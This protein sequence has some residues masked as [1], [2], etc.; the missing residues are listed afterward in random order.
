MSVRTQDETLG[1]DG[2][3]WFFGVVEDRM[4]PLNIGRVRV[5]CYGWHTD[6]ITQVPTESLPWAQ[7]MMP[8]NS[9]SISSI[10]LSGTGLVEGSTV[11]GFFLDGKN[12]Q[13]PMII[14]SIPGIPAVG[15][16]DGTTGFHDP[17]GI[18]GYP[19]SDEV[20][21]PDTPRLAYNRWTEDI[22]SQDK[23]KR[24]TISVPTA[25]VYSLPTVS[26]KKEYTPVQ[27][28]EPVQ[29]GSQQ[30]GY[31]FNHVH[32]TESGHAF[33]IDDSA[34]CERI[35]EYHRAG[36]FYE[37]QSDGSKTTKIV[38]DDFSIFVKNKNVLVQGDCNVTIKGN[39]RLLISGDYI[40]E[41]TGDNHITIQGS[42]YTKIKGNDYTEISSS[43]A[44]NISTDETLK[45]DSN[46]NIVIAK[47][48]SLNVNEHFKLR[49]KLDAEETIQ[50]DKVV[51]VFH[52]YNTLAFNNINITSGSNT[53]VGAGAEYNLKSHG[54][55]R[56]TYDST[57]NLS[58]TGIS[59]YDYK[60][61]HHVRYEADVLSYTGADTHLTHA[62]GV[63]HV[64]AA[65]ARTGD[66]TAT[67]AL[68]AS[69]L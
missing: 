26:T 31:P 32:Q 49:V 20:G 9:A 24:R 3:I 22:I 13:L 47:T 15:P 37:I 64:A 50:G 4:D 25:N 33:E 17:S 10:G 61:A 69:T 7:V 8:V 21:K 12:A 67:S 35:H 44:T 52:N 38:G 66:S 56:F 57:F 14:G 45:V 6:N 11:I 18:I 1:L 5:R 39:A 46:R 2:F 65:P 34:G 40:Q 28:D 27:W 30:S 16:G 42:R 53:N 68:T 48:D 62:T 23:A 51:T 19:T 58:I 60:A 43:R 36:T 55:S 63:D 54:P 41:V 59:I 29:R